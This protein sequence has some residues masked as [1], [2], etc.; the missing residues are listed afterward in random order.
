MSDDGCRRSIRKNR[1]WINKLDN[2][3]IPVLKQFYET[4]E[5]FNSFHMRLKLYPCPHCKFAGF[6][7]LHGF[8]YGYSEQSALI[9]I[10]RG[11]R[12]FCSNRNQKPGCGKTFSLLNSAFIQNFMLSAKSVWA[13]LEKI[14]DGRTPAEA[15]RQSGSITESSVYRLLKRVK[16]SQSGIRTWLT[17]IKNPPPI[18]HTAHSLT[19]TLLHLVTIFTTSACPIADFQYHFQSSFF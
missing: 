15:G 3:Q 11:H 5:Q 16:R 9:R 12:I 2:I 19:Q 6:L 8:L 10:Q 1:L 18:C 13:F 4:E 17:R 7:I 14:K